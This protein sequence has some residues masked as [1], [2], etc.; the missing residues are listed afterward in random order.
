MQTSSSDCRTCTFYRPA[1]RLS[2]NSPVPEQHST[3]ENCSWYFLNV[4]ALGAMFG[5]KFLAF[6]RQAFAPKA[7]SG[8]PTHAARSPGEL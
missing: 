6:L 5:G 7:N 1:E 2:A 3:V 8:S 4:A